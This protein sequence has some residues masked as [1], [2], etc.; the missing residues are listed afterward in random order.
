LFLYLLAEY[1]EVTSNVSQ[2]VRLGKDGWQKKA[3]SIG[4][5]GNV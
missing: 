2:S 3:R 1:E 4:A 5:V